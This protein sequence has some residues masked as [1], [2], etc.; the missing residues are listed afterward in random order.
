MQ[1]RLSKQ[2]ECII[3]AICETAQIKLTY[4]FKFRRGFELR[5]LLEFGKISKIL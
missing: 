1:I 5:K 4:D 2:R 3:L